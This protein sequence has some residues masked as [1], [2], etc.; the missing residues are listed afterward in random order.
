[1]NRKIDLLAII[2]LLLLTN[3]YHF[4]SGEC[5]NACS[6]HGHCSLFDMCICQRNWQGND[7]NQSK[8]SFF[9]VLDHFTF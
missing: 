1:M 6:G 7:C 4:A 5:A 3:L 2:F 9:F 8:N